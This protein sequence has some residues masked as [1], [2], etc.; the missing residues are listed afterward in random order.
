[1]RD[2]NFLRLVSNTITSR[3]YNYFSQFLHLIFLH[4]I[5]LHLIFLHLIFWKKWFVQLCSKQP[6]FIQ[7]PQ[8]I[9]GI[10]K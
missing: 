2:C 6:G 1:M 9:L 4:L 8:G 3:S 7:I 5:F 10:K